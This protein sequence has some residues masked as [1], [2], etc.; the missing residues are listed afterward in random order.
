MESYMGL[1]YPFMEFTDDAWVK[2]AALYWEKLGRIVPKWFEPDHDS[3]TVRLLTDELGFVKN[4][5]PTV[6]DQEIVAQMFLE[7]LKKHEQTLIER[8]GI[9]LGTPRHVKPRAPLSETEAQVKEKKLY[10][11][12]IQDYLQLLLDDKERFIAFTQKMSGL[13]YDKLREKELVNLVDEIVVHKGEPHIQQELLKKSA[14]IS[15]DASFEA[16]RRMERYRAARLSQIE[17]DGRCLYAPLTTDTGK[18]IIIHPKLAF[19]YVEVLADQ[20]ASDR[21]LHLVTDDV[22]SHVT[23]SGYT[24]ERLAQVLLAPDSTEPLFVAPRPQAGEVEQ[25][26]AAIALRS[27]IPRNLSEVPAKT[28]VK[29]R[30][31]YRDEMIAF[32]NAVHTLAKDL[33][34]LQDV[35]SFEAFKTHLE[36]TYERELK[37]QLNDFKRCLSSL[38]IDTI[39]SA[40]SIQVV[41]PPVLASTLT[42]AGAYFHLASINPLVLGAGALACSV[43]PVI[44]KKQEDRKQ[45]VRS[46]PMSYLFYVREQLEPVNVAKWVT[47]HTRKGLFGI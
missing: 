40:M 2:L 34:Q 19:A 3:D 45:L 5:Y 22:L 44:R 17:Y 35:G 13:L 1:Y 20:M 10:E 42:N 12:R 47:Q 27:V 43:F 16:S 25:H 14:P 15:R 39:T 28:I 33:E 21:K 23:T 7:V 8:Y 46:S 32:Q 31:Q 38:G 41:L 18:K 9:K 37:P 11:D 4:L 26:I 29:I 24:V 36:I 30:T 6:K